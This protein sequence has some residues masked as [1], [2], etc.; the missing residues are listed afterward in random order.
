MTTGGTTARVQ[1]YRLILL[2]N[3]RPVDAETL[4]PPSSSTQRVQGAP[5]SLTSNAPLQ[6]V[7]GGQTFTPYTIEGLVTSIAPFGIG[8][9]PNPRPTYATDVT[10]VNGGPP[11]RSAIT[12]K[13]GYFRIGQST[14]V[15]RTVGPG[16]AGPIDCGRVGIGTLVPQL[17]NS[18]EV[19]I[20]Q[21]TSVSEPALAWDIPLFMP[22]KDRSKMYVTGSVLAPPGGADT[23]PPNL[24]ASFYA[25]CSETDLGLVGKSAIAHTYGAFEV[26]VSR[27]SCGEGS[28]LVRAM[29]Y[30]DGKPVDSI[31][32]AA[33]LAQDQTLPKPLQAVPAS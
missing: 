11:G 16:S 6:S 7:S 19:P 22:P 5:A 25:G 23:L 18:V 24:V 26:E 15:C 28:G 33:D 1:A 8:G 3:G 14:Q 17:Y 29:L 13:D 27:P 21:H 12:G 9:T 32:F 4:W 31:T 20:T 10:W 30:E 2:E